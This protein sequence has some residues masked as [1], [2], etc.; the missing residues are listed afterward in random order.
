MADI[1]S[2]KG[3][4]VW[5]IKYCENG[6]GEVAAQKAVDSGFTHVTVKIL[7]GQWKYNQRPVE[8]HGKFS[9]W[10]D[11]IIKPWIA[12][13]KKR[14]IPVWGWQWVLLDDPVKEAR[15]A[16]DR[17]KDLA[18]DGFIINAE[19]PAKQKPNLSSQLYMKNLKMNVPIALSSYRYPEL[20]HNFPWQ[21][22]LAGCDLA[23]PQVY[24]EQAHNPGIQLTETVNQYRD[25]LKWEKDI[26]PTG[27]AYSRGDWY[28]TPDDA[29]IFLGVAQK[30]ELPSANFWEWRFWDDLP[31]TFEAISK[32]DWGDI[33]KPPVP[34]DPEEPEEPETPDTAN[35][36]MLSGYVKVGEDVYDAHDVEFELQKRTR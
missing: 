8:A 3:M 6:D 14:G 11:D 22:Y 2:G 24:W 23:M 35:F 7:N 33:E 21:I 27:S 20:H 13:F 19:A 32:Y 9:H 18:L 31:Q 12:E 30:L 17:V 26:V 16:I 34:P 25:Y 5:K 4:W 29:R 28:C 1:L 10:T 36:K 15:A